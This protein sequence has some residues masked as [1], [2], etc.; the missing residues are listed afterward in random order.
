MCL[1]CFWRCLCFNLSPSFRCR[2]IA[3][4]TDS[5]YVSQKIKILFLSAAPDDRARRRPEQELRDMDEALRRAKLRERFELVNRHA[6][7]P[8]DLRRAVLEETP[9]ILHFAGYGA[10]GGIALENGEGRSQTVSAAALAGLFRLF[11]EPL[12]CVVLNACFS[13]TQAEAISAH[14]AYVIGMKNAASAQASH[15]FAVGFYDALGNG[16]DIE[17]AFDYALS[18]LQLEGHEAEHLTPVLL[19]QSTS[20]GDAKPFRADEAHKKRIKRAQKQLLA[21][22]QGN[23]DALEQLGDGLFPDDE[24]DKTA[25]QI[26]SAL[27]ALPHGKALNILNQARYQLLKENQ[28]GAACILELLH[29][30]LPAVFESEYHFAALVRGKKDGFRYRVLELPIATKTVAEIVMAAA[31][32]RAT[33]FKPLAKGARLPEGRYLISLPPESGKDE[34]GAH[35]MQNIDRHMMRKFPTQ[36]RRRLVEDKTLVG[37]D[38][39]S[40]PEA[41]KLQVALDT[42]EYLA[43]EHPEPYSHYYLY[44][45]PEDEVERRYF[46]RIIE[47]LQAIYQAVAFIN[48]SAY[49]KGYAPESKPLN[50]LADLLRGQANNQDTP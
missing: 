25:A 47:K 45:L 44:I 28:P 40:L 33:A 17:F 34:N 7:R 27:L 2:L 18:A 22:L 19:R 9:D 43:T 16:K 48:L 32:G 24:D 20:E 37:S 15:D 10:D 1:L 50:P 21:A 31:D 41:E 35:Y 36:F 8:A 39:A 49:P 13:E 30:L 26:V 3:F 38:A 14:I 11:A 42:L 6:Q 4:H 5:K 23:D 29:I 46:Q 12:R